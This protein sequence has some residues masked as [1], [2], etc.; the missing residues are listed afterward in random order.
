MD[1]TGTSALYTV[2]EQNSVKCEMWLLVLF[3]FLLVGNWLIC[4]CILLIPVELVH[5]SEPILGW[6]LLVLLII[7]LGW[8]FGE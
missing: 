6:F 2:C 1:L 5:L 3:F 8:F 7:V 4:Q